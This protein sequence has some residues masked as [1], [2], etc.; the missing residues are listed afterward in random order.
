[1]K[2]I[3]IIIF[4]LLTILSCEKIID[5]E[6]PDSERK[7]VFNGIMNP[8]S[9][10]KIQVS[11]SLGILEDELNLK[12]LEDADVT[13]FEDGIEIEKMTHTVSG[14][15]TSTVV[16]AL[17]K[18]YKVQVENT[19]LPT[20]EASS[21][22]PELV[23]ITKLDTITVVT[24]TH[25]EFSNTDYYSTN[26]RFEINFDDPE[27]VDNYYFVGISMYEPIYDET[28]TTIIDSM[29]YFT[30]FMSEDIVLQNTE[31]QFTLNSI[32]GQAFSDEKINGFSYKLKI[33]TGIPTYGE[34]YFTGSTYNVY[35]MSI[36]KDL[37]LHILSY[38]KAQYSSNDPFTQPVQ[39]FS[40][41]TDGLGI[42]SAINITKKSVYVKF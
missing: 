23:E 3:F 12:Y 36:T 29:E 13:I 40:N 5:L 4:G 8:D 15:F 19:N 1:M 26:I 33:E 16:P 27:S 38:N 37:Y 42:F 22:I 21:K 20:A 9:T 11:Q 30:Y 31:S 7:I 39:I 35:M 2:K 25:D 28:N 14:I 32:S 41:I 24:T 34:A 6:I 10:I 18:T 17:N